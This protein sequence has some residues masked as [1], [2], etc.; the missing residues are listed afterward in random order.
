[1]HYLI[2]TGLAV[3]VRGPPQ[4]HLARAMDVAG[5]AGGDSGGAL[6]RLVRFNLTA[7]ALSI[8]NNLALMALLVG[9]LGA[10]T[11]SQSREHSLEF[12]DQLPGE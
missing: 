8:A 2:A 11:A 5:S 7:G 6:G 3:E 9:G 10:H 1:V 12:V 4:F